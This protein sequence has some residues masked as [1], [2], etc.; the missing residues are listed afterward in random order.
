MNLNFEIGAVEDSISKVMGQKKEMEDLQSKTQGYIPKV[1][2]AWRGGD[3]KEFSAD[4]QRKLLPA[5]QQ[6][7][8][9]IG[10]FGGNLGAVGNIMGQADAKVGSM[11]GGLSDMF[12]SFLK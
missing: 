1:E 7:I 4:V 6:L 8:E 9:A 12:G 11:V 5:I 3:E 2:G 10:G